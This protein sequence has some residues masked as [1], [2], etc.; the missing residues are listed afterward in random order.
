MKNNTAKKKKLPENNVVSIMTNPKFKLDTDVKAVLAELKVEHIKYVELSSNKLG[1]VKNDRIFYRTVFDFSEIK[2][3][4]LCVVDAPDKYLIVQNPSPSP[5]I[6]GIVE[7]F[8]RE[9]SK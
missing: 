1:F 7:F 2:N 4:T 3:T 9:V 6:L 5:N 8:Q